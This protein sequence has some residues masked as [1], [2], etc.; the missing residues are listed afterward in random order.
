M[1]INGTA[2]ADNL[3]GTDGDDEI[4]GYGGFDQINGKAGNDVIDGGADGDSIEGGLGDD[5]IDGGDGNDFIS[6]FGGGSDSLRGGLGADSISIGHY[7]PSTE[8]EQLAVEADAG[9]DRV[10]L[11]SSAGGTINIDLGEGADRISLGFIQKAAVTISTGSGRDTVTL[12]Q[13]A[14]LGS[15]PVLTDFQVGDLGDVLDA[16]GYLA[17]NA[18]NWDGSNP[19]GPGGYLRL[20]QSGSDVLLQ[21]DRDGA[22]GTAFNP[23]TLIQFTNADA[24]AFTAANLGG[25]SPSGDPVRGAT[26]DGGAGSDNLTGTVGDDVITGLGGFDQIDGSAGNDVIDGGADSDSIQGG[27]G[28]DVIDGG[29]GDDF[30][31]DDGGSDILRGGAGADN[32]SVFHSSN[33]LMAAAETIR[34]EGGSGDDRVGYYVFTPGSG[35]IDLGAGADRL[36]LGNGPGALRATLGAGRDRVELSS[37]APQNA[38]PVITDFTSGAD[39][40]NI[41]ITSIFTS[42]L[43]GWDGSNPFGASGHLRLVQAG[44][45]TLFQIDRDGLVGR[46]VGFQTLARLEG[47]SAASLTADNFSGYAPS[48]VSAADLATAFVTAPALATEG[49]DRAFTLVL[50]L[51]DVTSLNTAVTMTF[52]ADQSTAIN[53]ADVNAGSFYGTYAVTQSPAGE[54]RISL[55]TIAVLDDGLIEPEETVSIR[56]TATGQTFESG[57]DSIVVQ[58]KL[59]SDDMG[60]TAGADTLTGNA[61]GDVLRGLAGADVLSGL[62]GRDLL[63]GGQGNDLVSG[64]AEGD[65]FLFAGSTLGNDRISDFGLDDVLVT[66]ARIADKDG[67]GRIAFGSDRDLDLTGGGQVVITT[68]TGARINSLEYDGSFAANGITYFVYS[69]IGSVAGVADADLLL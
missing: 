32:I 60:G 21:F 28:N 40:D 30:I 18:A 2:A 19:F 54:Y 69:R 48:F 3:Q 6:D 41:E 26:I 58:V 65:G 64:G 38:I 51:K 14:F 25:Y 36:M 10:D 49:A 43:Q 7:G 29:D 59:R 61:G 52:L 45:D 4:S 23:V 63:E 42:G 15:A 5:V 62:G 37:F 17:R 22:A 39:G 56:I 27:F 47:A 9:D 1:Q 16:A 33:G 12:Q 66:T 50:V 35:T 67:D 11:N 46:N 34:V 8:L 31:S 68:E 13:S 24:T 53:G 20:S 55:G 44:A 57:T